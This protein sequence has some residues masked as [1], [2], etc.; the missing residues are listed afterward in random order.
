MRTIRLTAVLVTLAMLVACGTRIDDEQRHVALAGAG[1]VGGGGAAAGGAGGGG[2]GSFGAEPGGD[3][4]GELVI[5]DLDG[6][7][8]A[9][10]AAGAGPDDPAA[11]GTDAGAAV[12]ESGGDPAGGDGA[13]SA[14]EAEG[15]A[16]AAGGG[17][18]LDPRQVP[19]GGNG[20]ATDTGVSENRI[21]VGNISDVSGAVP[22][23]FEPEQLAAQAR[24]AFENAR[25]PI[26]GRQLEFLPMDGR[27]NSGANRAASI[28]AC[29][30]AFANVGSMSAFDQGGAPIIDE[31]GIPDV[32]TAAT[33]PPMQAVDNAYPISITQPDRQAIGDYRWIDQQYPGV[34]DAAAYL[35]I[36]GEVTQAST[37]KT[38]DATAKELGW[39]W[40]YVQAIQIAETNY[41]P[42]VIRMREEGIRFVTFQ[43]AYQQAVRLA[44]AMEQQGFEPDVYLLQSNTYNPEMLQEGGAAM[45][46]TLI[47]ITSVMV[48]E[49][50][51]NAELQR[52][53]QWLNQVAPGKRPTSLGMYSWSATSLFIEIAKRVGPEL[54]RARVLEELAKIDKWDGGGLHP[55]INVGGRVPN[56][57]FIMVQIRGG[58][59][60][61]AH[62]SSGFDCEGPT[63]RL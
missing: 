45:E 6:G 33:T 19:P 22:G 15:N 56:Q 62:P 59:F 41:A 39:N 61:R 8:P 18:G 40:K 42:F 49:A 24:V 51:N 3:G 26:F 58:Q 47:G 63:V 48:E 44:R 5:D 28:E 12:A 27:L 1:G 32:R 50:G 9:F 55:P 13:A 30:R 38:R 34:G 53:A 23:L 31:C 57:C 14:A 21:V 54:T 36:D 43:G 16:A 60:T 25:G 20:G 17:G 29:E 37:K 35:F 11:G 2:D 7:D 4:G 10:D 46:G 52:Y